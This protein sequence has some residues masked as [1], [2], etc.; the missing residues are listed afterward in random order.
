MDNIPGDDVTMYGGE[1]PELG[2]PQANSLTSSTILTIG[3]VIG[4][5]LLVPDRGDLVFVK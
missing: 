2:T 4:S 3:S 5:P 1:D